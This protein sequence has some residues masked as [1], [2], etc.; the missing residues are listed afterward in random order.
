MHRGGVNLSTISPG[1]FDGHEVAPADAAK[2]AAE[3]GAVEANIFDALALREVSLVPSGANQFADVLTF[4]ADASGNPSGV[5]TSLRTFAVASL[6]KLRALVE[7]HAVPA[8]EIAPV[9]A[10]LEQAALAAAETAKAHDAPAGSPAATASAAAAPESADGV[11]SAAA[12]PTHTPQETARM[13]ATATEKT[14]TAPTQTAESVEKAADQRL[15]E[16]EKA[17]ADAKRQ[18]EVLAA[19]NAALSS[20]VEKLAADAADRALTEKVEKLFAG[21]PGE[22]AAFKALV[23][24]LDAETEKTL[25]GVLAFARTAAEEA[26]VFKASGAAGSTAYASA[27]V[28]SSPAHAAFETKVQEIM[29]TEKT[30][31]ANASVIAAERYREL[32]TALVNEQRTRSAANR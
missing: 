17:L 22:P 8:E 4:K 3:A 19:Q 24:K 29:S 9:L 27:M 30:D 32:A 21:V 11:S 25:D 20:T 26:Q 6:A 23:A 16:V 2:G 13:S 5:L 15:I 28:A 10:G 31:Y 7:K 18:A 12:V 1:P 14:I